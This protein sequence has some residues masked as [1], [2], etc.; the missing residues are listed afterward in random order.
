VSSPLLEHFLQEERLAKWLIDLIERKQKIAAFPNVRYRL[1]ELQK[2]GAD[3]E[4]VL[5]GLVLIFPAAVPSTKRLLKERRTRLIRLADR[6]ERMAQEVERIVSD[7]LMHSLFW[8]TMLLENGADFTATEK[9]CWGARKFCN[10]FKVFINF[11]RTESKAFQEMA[12]T[13]E[14]ARTNDG[15]VPVLKYV[16]QSTGKFHDDCMA[17]LL[18][19]AHDAFGVEATFSAEMLRKL[20]QR[21]SPELIRKRNVHTGLEG[22]F[23]S[24]FLGMPLGDLDKTEV[25]I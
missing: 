1:D 11:F 7:P 9:R 16:K 10:S 12:R 18:Q 21:K 4:F 24:D 17:D 23:G 19:A 14:D 15:I 2:A 6:L 25:E 5:I 13:Y 3:P 20:R 8:R 22:L